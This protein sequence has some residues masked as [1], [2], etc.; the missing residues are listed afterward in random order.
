MADPAVPAVRKV[1]GAMV[2]A[3]AIACPDLRGF[4]DRAQDEPLSEGEWPGYVVRYD[5]KWHLAPEGG[6]YYHTA[7]FNFECQSGNAGGAALDL[8]NQRS[9]A[10]IHNVLMADPSLGGMLH[11]LQPVGADQSQ[12][13]SSDVG[14][15]I[16]QVV[17][18]YYTLISDI[19]V[20]V[21]VGGQNFP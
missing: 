21:G 16:L 17:A 15:A 8:I 18:N 9:V 5:A 6:Q 3:I 14:S 2:A 20:I 12:A 13:E 7:T 4:T 19:S 10:A 11:D 1:L